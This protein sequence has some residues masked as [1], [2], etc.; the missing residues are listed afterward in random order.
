MEME[1]QKKGWLQDK[2]DRVINFCRK[3]PDITLTVI[4]GFF[5]LAGALVNSATTR[6]EFKDY[7]YM[8]DGDDVFKIPA[9]SMNSKK[10]KTIN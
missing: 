5:T 8:T 2:K 3:H 6:N 9:K 1:E 4:G 7:V 10:L